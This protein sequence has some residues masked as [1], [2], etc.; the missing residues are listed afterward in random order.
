MACVGEKCQGDE[1]FW[2]GEAVGDLSDLGVH[3]FDEGVGQV[4]VEGVVDLGA[5][6]SDLAGQ[7]EEVRDAAAGGP[8]KPS[9]QCGL[10][11]GA[12]DLEYVA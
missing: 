12:F 1:G 6:S 9:V 4:V 10:P 5:V 7:F 11:G 3:G 2:V 8:G